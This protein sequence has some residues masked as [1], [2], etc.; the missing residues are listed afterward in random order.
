[1]DY[2]RVIDAN[3]NTERIS[4]LFSAANLKGKARLAAH[5]VAYTKDRQL[6][7]SEKDI[8]L[9]RSRPSIAHM[10]RQAE[11]STCYNTCFLGKSHLVTLRLGAPP[12]EF[13]RGAAQA[14]TI[15]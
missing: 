6:Q 10:R 1:M 7:Q 8:M 14:S 4:Y 5:L 11:L 9:T 12:D 15:V 3:H 2:M 13:A